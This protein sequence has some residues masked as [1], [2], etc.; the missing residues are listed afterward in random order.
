MLVNIQLVYL[1]ALGL[2]SLLCPFDIFV[3]LSLGFAWELARFSQVTALPTTKKKNV[4]KFWFFTIV[5]SPKQIDVY[6]FGVLLCELC[7]NQ[8]PNPD[9]R[10]RQI[11]L[12]WNKNLRDLTEQCIAKDPCKRSTMSD[13]ITVLEPMTMWL[14]KMMLPWWIQWWISSNT[15]GADGLLSYF[16]TD[17]ITLLVF[18]RPSNNGVLAN[19]MRG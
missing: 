16:N 6:S 13:V 7:I 14:H 18:L 15:D 11:A 2:P 9:E 4:W 3:S 12:M 1:L 19:T 17:T 8:T 10:E 5:M